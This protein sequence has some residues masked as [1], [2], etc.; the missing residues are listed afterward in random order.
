MME[1]VPSILG[2]DID[3]EEFVSSVLELD[4]CDNGYHIFK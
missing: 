4:Y 1:I 2:Q 3:V